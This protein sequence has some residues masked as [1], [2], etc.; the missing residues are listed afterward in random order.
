MVRAAVTSD[1]AVG[2]DLT[3][4]NPRLDVD[5]SV[6]SAL[7]DALAGALHEGNLHV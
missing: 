3:I 4:F 7:V 5:G 6:T 1:M 2:M